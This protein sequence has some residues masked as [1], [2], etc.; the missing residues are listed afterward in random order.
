MDDVL[1]RNW[2]LV[3]LR[4]LVALLFGIA[5]LYRPAL[6]LAFLVF[7]FGAYAFIDGIFS[8]IAAVANRH[9]QPYRVALLVSGIVGIIIG[10]VTYITPGVTALAL[11]YFI[12]AWAIVTGLA[13][14]AAAIRPRKVVAG[15]WLL[16]LAGVLSVLFGVVLDARP[17]AGALVVT[18]WIGAYAILFGILLLALA[19]RLRHWQHEDHTHTVPH[20]V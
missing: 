1:A 17:G 9:D 13:Q 20:A 7:L 18:L 2:G 6:T 14:I 8:V 4:G 3:A 19:F 16:A 12:A 11:L 10:V 15:E 5:T